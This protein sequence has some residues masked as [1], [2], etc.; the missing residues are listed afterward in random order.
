[1]PKQP[2]TTVYASPATVRRLAGLAHRRGYVI[3][4]GPGTGELGSV[5]QFLEA[6]AG[7]EIVAVGPVMALADVCSGLRKAA[8]APGLTV[9]E[10]EALTGLLAQIESDADFGADDL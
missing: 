5:S 1:L 2:S 7:G 6:L 8:T 4:R 10:Q 9:R 3:T